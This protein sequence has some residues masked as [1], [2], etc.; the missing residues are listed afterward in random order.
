MRAALQKRTARPARRHGVG[1]SMKSLP[2][3]SENEEDAPEAALASERMPMPD[4]DEVAAMRATMVRRAKHPRS[5]KR[6]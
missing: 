3:L 4:A 5:H 2:D 6:N 1:G